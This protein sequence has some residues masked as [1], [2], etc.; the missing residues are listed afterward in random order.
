MVVTQVG[1]PV[2]HMSLPLYASILLYTGN[3]IYRDL[4]A[5]LR[6]EDRAKSA[7][8]FDYL[9]LFF[10]AVDCMPKVMQSYWRGISCDLYDQ[11]TDGKEIIWWSISSLTSEESVARNF[12]R[13]CGGNCTLI[14]MRAK[15]AMDI[16][17]MSF[18]PN[19]KE[20]LLAPGTKLKVVSRKRIG[21]V[22]EIHMEEIGSAL[23]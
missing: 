21:N 13:S 17:A 16:S 10:A 4:N 20:S 12:M 23:E 14:V 2:K 3:S 15:S 11:Y 19:E 5:T 6:A 22:S 1:Q 18:Y 9:R 7:R 8:Y